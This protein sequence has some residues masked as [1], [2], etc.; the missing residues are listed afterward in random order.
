MFFLASILL[1]DEKKVQSQSLGEIWMLNK[2]KMDR[3]SLY[4]NL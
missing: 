1:L 3:L 4:Y 2:L